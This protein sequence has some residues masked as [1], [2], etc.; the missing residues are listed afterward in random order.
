L[1]RGFSAG[2]RPIGGASVQ[3]C[4]RAQSGH[5]PGSVC[6]PPASLPAFSGVEPLFSRL[7]SRSG[8]PWGGRRSGAWLRTASTL[9]PPV[10]RQAAIRPARAGGMGVAR[11][12]RRCA[13]DG[14]AS[15]GERPPS[16]RKCRRPRGEKGENGSGLLPRPNAIR[17]SQPRPAGRRLALQFRLGPPASSGRTPLAGD[18]GRSVA[19]PKLDQP[20][21]H[22]AD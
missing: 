22:P 18:P 12:N 17:W 8:L 5:G 2:I 6:E 1:L 21:Q 16:L 3:A 15:A 11:E 14:N 20:G 13:A 9:R 7:F 19:P 10:A 4:K